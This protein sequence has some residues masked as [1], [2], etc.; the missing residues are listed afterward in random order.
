MVYVVLSLAF[1]LSFTF[2]LSLEDTQIITKQLHL[3]LRFEY[4]V[5]HPGQSV[6]L[7]NFAVAIPLGM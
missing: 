2:F 7:Y 5:F 1:G 4:P 6:C 3:Y